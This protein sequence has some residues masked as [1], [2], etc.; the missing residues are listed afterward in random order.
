MA[1]RLRVEALAALSTRT[2]FPEMLYGNAAERAGNLRIVRDTTVYG[3]ML[4]T[5]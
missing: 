5:R 4:S 2:L 3:F 1:E